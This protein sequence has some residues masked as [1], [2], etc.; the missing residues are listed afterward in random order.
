MK[1]IIL[2]RHGKSDW[3]YEFLNDIDR[4]LNER[5][6]RET[7]QQSKWAK[8]NLPAPQLIISSPAIRA[9]STALIFARTLHYNEQ[10]ILIRHG[11]YDATTDD[12][13]NNIHLLPT[14]IQ[15]VLFFGHNPTI[16]NLSNLL[17]SQSFIDNIPTSGIV[18]LDFNTNDWTKIGELKSSQFAYKFVK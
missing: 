5:G 1:T 9:I 18:R 4:P 3:G 10:N 12:F 8:D 15:T 16:T 13:L 11:I 6:Y 2:I 14:S 7:Y 17:N